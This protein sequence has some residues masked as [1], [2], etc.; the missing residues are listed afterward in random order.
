[1]END[2]LYKK[3]IYISKE[4]RAIIEE[5]CKEHRINLVMRFINEYNL[6]KFLET[7]LR[8]LNGVDYLIIDLQAITTSTSEDEITS[9]IELIRRMYNVRIIILAEGYKEGNVLLGRLFNLG[10]YNIITA[11]NDVI[12]AD[13]IEKAFSIEGMTFGNA[14]KYKINDNMLVINKTTKVVKENIKRVKQTI[15]IGIAGTERHIGATTVAINIVK[16]LSELTNVTACYIENNQHNSIYSLVEDESIP[17]IYNEVLRKI[18]YKGIDLYQRPENLADILKFE[19]EF[20]VFDFGNFDEMSK[21]EISSFLTRDLK[22]IVSGNKAWEINKLIETFMII[23][24]DI[25]S[26]LMFNFVRNEDKENF[27]ESLGKFWKERASFSEFVPEPFIIG[28]KSFY[29]KVLKD[30]LLNT[31]IEEIKD[32]KG[33]LNIFK[34]KRDKE[35]VKKK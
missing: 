31:T 7:E 28:N 21:E 14:M 33:L 15:T 35:D 4:P 20:Y 24:E 13:E 8:N 22:I 19:Y 30:Y 34:K 25:N 2:R 32:K 29:E 17:T 12:F 5:Y 10:I 26:Y 3:Y 6:K 18:T 1:M 23:G 16:Y 27:K 9:S 11:K